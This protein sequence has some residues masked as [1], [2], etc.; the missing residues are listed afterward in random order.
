[1][2]FPYQFKLRR[3]MYATKEE[4]EKRGLEKLYKFYEKWCGKF[5]RL[6]A[7]KLD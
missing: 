6:F 7:Y 1:M 4:K 3:N 2:T 5:E